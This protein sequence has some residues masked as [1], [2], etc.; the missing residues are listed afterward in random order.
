MT[1]IFSCLLVLIVFK[2]NSFSYRFCFFADPPEEAYFKEKAVVGESFTISCET[3][4]HPSPNYTI[5][6]NDS[7]VVSNDKTYTID[8]VQYSDAGLYKCVAENKL[9]SSSKM[10]QLSVIG[11]IQYF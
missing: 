11:K 6:Y 3:N 2:N 7:L 8:N 5:I 1:D 4:G 10:Y 9:G